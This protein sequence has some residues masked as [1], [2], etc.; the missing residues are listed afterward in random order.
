MNSKNLKFKFNS[1][2]VT[3]VVIAAVI[4][5]NL[6]VTTLATKVNLKIDL[7]RAQKFEITEQT[8]DA[9]SKLSAPI[10]VKVLGKKDEVSLEV[11][12]YLDRYSAMNPNFRVNYI[13]VYQNQSVFYTYVS[14]GE[15]LQ[16]G[17]IVLESGDRYKIISTASLYTQS[18]STVEGESKY[19]FDLEM[20]L[21][22]AVVTLSGLMKESA[23]YLLEGHSEMSLSYFNQ[24]LS[25]QGYKSSNINIL[26]NEIPE[27]AVMLVS[28][29]PAADFSAEE[30]EKIDK[31]L[32][33]GGNFMVIYTAGVPGLPRLE[34]YLNEWGI[35][36]TSNLVLEQNPDKV[37][38]GNPVAIIAD[39]QQHD[40]TS[41][42]IAQKTPLL[43]IESAGFGVTK[44]NA[45]NATAQILISAS[46]KAVGKND[47]SAMKSYGFEE[48]DVTGAIGM[49]AI[50]EKENAKV[51]VIG[52]A[53]AVEVSSQYPGNSQ[54]VSSVLSYLTDNG[55]NLKIS[56]K[57]V[58]EG[59]ITNLTQTSINVMYYVLVWGLP[60]AILLAGIIIWLKR[61]YL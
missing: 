54:L 61:R 12:E 29:I 6:I 37:Y 43:F 22:N 25:T 32:Q 28:C 47:L 15:T 52:S 50:S 23:V 21:T 44:S 57:V 27:D 53:S 26:N 40:I 18:L 49:V 34:S 17:D 55:E 11:V 51:M 46:D 9:M 38:N 39:A 3:A 1:L 45:Q 13:D 59:K 7:T 5:V 4:I 41:S 24:L 2:I 48:G 56:P 42:V 58:T 60:A 36:K 33:G 16:A 35:Q 20:K 14:K 8:R 30:C 10:D 31:F 19:N